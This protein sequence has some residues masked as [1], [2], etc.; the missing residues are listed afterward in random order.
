LN[1][2]GI[3]KATAVL[4]V[5]TMLTSCIP[6]VNAGDWYQIWEEPTGTVVVGVDRTAPQPPPWQDQVYATKLST[7]DIYKMRYIN[8]TGVYSVEWNRIGGPGNMFVTAGWAGTLYGR[9][10]GWPG[11]WGVHR[12]DYGET[13]TVID[14]FVGEIYGGVYGLFSTK[15]G[16]IY[17]Y[18]EAANTWTKIGG[19][20]KMFAVGFDGIYRLAPDGMSVDGYGEGKFWANISGPIYGGAIEKIYIGGAG[21]ELYATSADTGDIYH[22]T[23]GYITMPGIFIP[24]VGQTPSKKVYVCTWT[25]IGGPG[26]M[27]AVNQVGDLYRLSTDGSIWQ[28]DGT[29][30]QWTKIGAGFGAIYAGGLYGLYATKSTTNDLWYY[31]AGAIFTP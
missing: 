23:C 15:S 1:N 16:D 26:K 6:A 3:C 29:P 27:F 18:N 14:V 12:H 9:Y 20:G 4:I 11:I 31:D 5:M 28:Y 13:W 7:G 2:K 30:E 19:P 10:W 25:K 24:G 22:H 8:D 21:D 17:S